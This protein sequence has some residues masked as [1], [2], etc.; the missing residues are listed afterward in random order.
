MA[1]P[2]AGMLFR[3]GWPQDLAE[4]L[5]YQTAR[6][7]GHDNPADRQAVVRDTYAR[8]A[9][10]ENIQGVPSLKQFL[11]AH[12]ADLLVRWCALASPNGK[13]PGHTEEADPWGA[14][15]P[16]PPLLPEVPP[17]PEH[18]L[19]P[20]LR[21]WLS[22]VARRFQV[23]LEFVAI[24]TLVELAALVGRRRGI[25]PKRY[26]DW[27]VVPNLW[28]LLVGR[29]GVLKTPSAEEALRPLKRL[30]VQ[31][32][33]T[34]KQ[35]AFEAASHVLVYQA[36]R[37]ALQASL[38][39]LAKDKK[40]TAA[41]LEAIRQEIVELERKIQAV[42]AAEQRY[43]VS[44]ATVEKLGELL[45]QN[46]NGL[47]LYRDELSGWLRSLDKTGREGDREFYLESWTGTG[48]YT[49]DRGGVGDDGLL[50]RFQLAVWPD[51]GTWENVDRPP[52]RQAREEAF[53]LFKRLAELDAST[54]GAVVDEDTGIPV[55]RF[56]D[57]A[58]ELFDEWRAGLEHRLRS[59][60]LDSP[61]FEAHLSKYRSLMPSLALLFHLSAVV[62]HADDM[63]SSSS[64]VTLAA[65]K[66]AASWCEFLELH[67]RRVYAGA[68]RRDIQAAQALMARIRAGEVRDGDPVRVIYRHHW[69]LLNMPEAV[70]MALAVLERHNVVR[71]QQQE[72]GGRRTEVVLINPACSPQSVE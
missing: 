36:Q 48:G 3:A 26:D 66:L 55:L 16:P 51:I 21:P 65:A 1:L 63:P 18:L 53:T 20:R 32:L 28:G 8:A 44:D 62:L 31:T 12:I 71:I 25:H 23:P 40:A 50:Q 30:V 34:R 22:D 15:R 69:T 57:E 64:G 59:G 41:Q 42:A 45:Q 24:P 72:T 39:Q 2:V 19:P 6:I 5:I 27:L 11:P 13:R 56:A 52:N 47:L 60:A 10:G 35:D 61:A 14:V 37:D 17:L 49:V 58:Q 7:A 67:A 68:L 54:V 43:L 29:P 4:Q 33:D 46:P 9:R 38:K 70:D